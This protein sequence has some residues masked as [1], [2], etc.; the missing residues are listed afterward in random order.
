MLTTRLRCSVK[1]NGR[2]R[3]KDVRVDWNNVKRDIKKI[4]C[5]YANWIKLARDRVKRWGFVKAVLNH[6]S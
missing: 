3:S 1:L 4:G 2:A 6:W 5:K